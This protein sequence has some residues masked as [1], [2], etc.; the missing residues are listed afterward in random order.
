MTGRFL[1]ADPIE[2]G[3]DNNYNYP[4]D[5]VNNFDLDGNIAWFAVIAAGAYLG[6]AA[7]AAYEAYRQ[8]TPANIAWAAVAVIPG[9]GLVSKPLKPVVK[10][11]APKMTAK[12]TQYAAKVS[13]GFKATISRSVNNLNKKYPWTNSNPILRVGNGRVSLGQAP[14]HFRKMGI[15]GKIVNP[16]SG[17]FEGR[18]GVITVNWIK[19]KGRYVQI[20][21][22]GR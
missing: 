2:G 1:Q 10:A 17:H 18:I 15:L 14:Q 5:P 16:V 20:K 19:I 12:V 22:W 8:P 3:V 7:G 4:N 6:F 13:G 9:A 21:L 11:I